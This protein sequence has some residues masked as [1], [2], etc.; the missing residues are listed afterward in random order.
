MLFT[1]GTQQSIE[2]IVFDLKELTVYYRKLMGEVKCDRY[3]D[4]PGMWELED[5]QSLPEENHDLMPD[6]HLKEK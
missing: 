1:P 2:N 4:Q 6:L 3:Y 5:L